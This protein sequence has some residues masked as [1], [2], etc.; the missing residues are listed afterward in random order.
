VGTGGD[1]E[2][3]LG[4]TEQRRAV[5]VEIEDFLREHG[6]GVEVRANLARQDRVARIYPAGWRR[7]RLAVFGPLVALWRRDQPAAQAVLLHEVA[8]IRT[9]DQ[10]FLGLGSPFVALANLWL[11]LLT[12]FGVLPLAGFALVQYPTAQALSAQLL[13][14][15]TQ[16]PRVL[17]LPV[18]A[19]W[20]AELAADRYVIDCGLRTELLRALGTQD[21]QGGRYLRALTHLSHPPRVLRRCA[22]RSG[23]RRDVT[24]LASW[25]LLVLAQLLITLSS[26]IPASLLLG[27]PGQ[28]VIEAAVRNSGAFLADSARLWGPAAVLLLIWPVVARPWTRWWAG[29]TADRPSMPMPTYMTAALLVTI[30]LLT[31]LLL[32]SG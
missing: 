8:H 5:I 30:V 28:Q 15:L 11:L 14:L 12:V 27:S 32:L 9:G 22:L 21:R 31:P 29:H 13:L 2:H 6:S 19:L 4:L 10:L 3:R 7:A 23:P 1:V 24:L 20:L 16:V 25:P 17:L 18:G 26:A